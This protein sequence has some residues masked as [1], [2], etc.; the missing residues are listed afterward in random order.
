MGLTN[1]KEEQLR[2]MPVVR[3]GYS[4]S[5]DG[6][7]IIHKTVITTIRPLEYFEKV[8]SS[9]GEADVQEVSDA[10]ADDPLS[11]A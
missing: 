3:S 6:K 1:K 4:K 9:E 8:L 5:K 11:V 2:K 10:L 7:Y